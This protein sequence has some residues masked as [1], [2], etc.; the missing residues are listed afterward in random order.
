M[1]DEV[2]ERIRRRAGANGQDPRQAPRQSAIGVELPPMALEKRTYTGSI[3]LPEIRPY[4]RDRRSRREADEAR[5]D[6]GRMVYRSIKVRVAMEAVRTVSTCGVHSIDQAQEEM[7]D[8]LYAKDRHEGMN[9][10]LA[11][12]IAQAIQQVTAQTLALAELH[13]K[14][15]TEDL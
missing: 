10:L 14:R 2:Y 4:G 15:Q 6:L 7:M 5:R 13:Y 12:A 9:E 1:N 11:Q 8:I 3:S